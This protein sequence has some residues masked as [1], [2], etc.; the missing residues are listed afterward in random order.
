[1]A[2]IVLIALTLGFVALCV[3]Y[4]AWCDRIIGPD[5]FGPDPQLLD[6]ARPDLAQPAE[7]TA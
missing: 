5:D 1:M 6:A 3:A 7:V 2:D 4:I